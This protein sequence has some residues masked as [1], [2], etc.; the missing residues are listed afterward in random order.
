MRECFYLAQQYLR[1]HR[2]TTAV[3]VASIT[4]IIYLPIGQLSPVTLKRI[5]VVH[6]LDGHDKRALAKDYIW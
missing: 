3:L 1:H 6:I 5:R 4:L 2:L